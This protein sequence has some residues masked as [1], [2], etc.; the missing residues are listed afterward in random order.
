MRQQEPWD[1]KEMKAAAPAQAAEPRVPRVAVVGCGAIAEIFHLPALAREP[2]V[3]AQAILVDPDARRAGQLAGRFGAA[4]TATDYREVLDRVDGIVLAVPHHLHYPIAL[5]AL[6]QGRHVL[7]EKPL[8]EAATQVEELVKAAQAHDVSLAVNNTMRFYP[9][10]RKVREL[11]QEHAIGE[12]LHLRFLMGE[13][14]DWPAATGFYVGTGGARRGVLLDKG[15]HALDLVCW[16]LG[17]RPTLTRY[18]DDSCGGIEAVASVFF[19]HARCN[20]EVHLSWLSRF[21]NSYRI[22]GSA[23]AVEGGLFEWSFIILEDRWGRRQRVPLETTAREPADFGADVM[24]NFL[25]ILRGKATAVVSAGAVM[26]SISLIE[27]CYARR[28]PYSMPW[29]TVNLERPG[30]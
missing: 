18:Q 20:G 3:I 4:T 15:A 23:G 30:A 10:C 8:A 5:D 6:R 17:G 24:A 22:E 12:P 19:T 16:W 28:E 13:K 9:S 26:E 14:F 29:L 27:E 7:C 21:E 11:I 1:P 2:A 25:D